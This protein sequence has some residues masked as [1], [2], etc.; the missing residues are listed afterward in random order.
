MK[1]IGCCLFGVV[2]SGAACTQKSTEPADNRESAY[3]ENNRGVAELE[4]YSYDKAA[5]SFRRA[6]SIDE[7]VVV[8]HVN[9]AIALYYDSKLDEAATAAATARRR[10]PDS[11]HAIF[12]DGLIARARNRAPDAAAAFSRVLEIDP[13]DAGAMINLG[14]IYAQQRRERDAI[15]LFR[16]AV[17]IEP[18]NATAIYSLGQALVRTGAAADGARVLADFERVR[19]MG[20]AVTYSQTYLEQGRYAEA[21][22]SSGL[23]PDLVDAATPAVRF[24]DQTQSWGGAATAVGAL[25]LTDIDRDGDLDLVTGHQQDIEVSPWS[26]ARFAEPATVTGSDA[27]VGLV[28]ADVDNDE[29]IDILALHTRGLSLHQQSA[30][31]G[32]T[33]FPSGATPAANASTSSFQTAAL[34]DVDHDGDLDVLAGGPGSAGSPGT[35]RL[36]R[37]NGAGALT[38][39]TATAKL[40]ST[41]M[42]LALAPTDY[43]NRRDIDVLVVNKG[44]APQL[45]QNQRDGSFRDVGKSVGLAVSMGGIAVASG[46][47]NRDGYSDFVFAKGPA[48][49]EVAFSDGRGRFLITAGPDGSQGLAA[50]QCADYDNDGLLDLVGTGESGLKVFRNL[51]GRFVDVTSAAASGVRSALEPLGAFAIGDVDGDGDNDIAAVTASGSLRLFRNDGAEQRSSVR[52]R[53]RGV[54]SNRTAVGAKVEIRAGSMW[55]RLEQVAATPPVTGQDLIAGLGKHTVADVVRVWWPAG[56]VQAETSSGDKPLDGSKP[57]VITE[58]NRKPSSCPFLYSWN[59]HAF[60][61]VSDFLG[62]GELGYW[63]GPHGWSVPDRDEYVR[64]SERQ[65]VPRNCRLEL[66]V[67]NELEE[68]LYLDHLQLLSIEHPPDVEV[69]PREGMRAAAQVG[70]SLVA[71]RNVQTLARVVTD[72]GEDVTTR[73]VRR[74]GEAAS[75]F[76]PTAI[77]GYANAHALIFEAGAVPADGR[78]QVLLLTGWTD[79]AFSSDNVAATQRGWSLDPPRLEVRAPGGQW[80]LLIAD[81]GIPV[82]RPQ[83]IAV[84]IGAAAREP[85]TQFRLSTNMQIHWDVMA[86]AD[87]ASGVTLEPRTHIIETASLAWRGYSAVG[88]DG[89]TPSHPPDYA[90]VSPASPWK[91]FPG[92]YTGEGDVRALLSEP[93]DLFVVART[94]DELSLAFLDVGGRSRRTYLLRTEGYSKEMDLNS[95]SPDHVLPLPFRGLTTYPAVSPSAE[96]RARQRAMLNRDNTRVVSRPLSAVAGHLATPAVKAER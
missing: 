47:L 6:I 64:L 28:A 39:I 75:G 54:V 95:S 25:T 65:L 22:A 30:S 61:F 57:I 2:L 56:I 35:L 8:P 4:Q 76:V 45:F 55:Q 52:V 88:P 27:V 89:P 51:G 96:V 67:T 66:R 50:V 44:G 19:E 59:G 78:S 53:L 68:V 63:S 77:R 21:I 14:Q 18:A 24:S 5:E 74:D 62:G 92:H 82:G 26:G 23:E 12:I 41:G 91:V 33:P 46:D 85:G 29:R 13:G 60:E 49:A 15:A 1:A 93:D 38:D 10:L 48:R 83:T 20:A 81:V 3:Q 16:A 42:P 71:V 79:Y 72:R 84:D 86:I 7:R 87:L 9:L 80:R 37:N 70:L 31:G 90:R 34:L 17:A 32:F 36:F 73:V 40:Q 94:G 43:D 11:P 58:L 69:F